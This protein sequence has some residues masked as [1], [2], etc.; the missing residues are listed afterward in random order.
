[1][2]KR[3]CVSIQHA[4]IKGHICLITESMNKRKK[5]KRQENNLYIVGGEEK[6]TL[7]TDLGSGQKEAGSNIKRV[8]WA[9][10]DMTRVRERKI[11]KS[12]DTMSKE[13]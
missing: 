5:G 4:H 9:E 6:K 13:D 2:H 8:N 7:T 1:M 11:R 10:C 3:L 12:R